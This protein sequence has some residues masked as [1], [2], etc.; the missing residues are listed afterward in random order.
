MPNIVTVSIDE[1]VE[2]TQLHLHNCTSSTKGK[3]YYNIVK[4]CALPMQMLRQNLG[5]KLF[6][7][8]QHLWNEGEMVTGF[9]SGDRTT[10]QG[11][12]SLGQL[13]RELWST[14]WPSEC[15]AYNAPGLYAPC[16]VSH[17]IRLHKTAYNLGQGCSLSQATLDDMTDGNCLWR[18][19]WFLG[20]TCLILRGMWAT[21]LHIYLTPS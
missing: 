9:A 10:I 18:Y 1:M 6:I 7:R 13:R 20:S 3:N 2:K 4:S 14:Y 19:S 12:Q 15:P 17:Q 16:S 8:D 11:H 21:H 5:C